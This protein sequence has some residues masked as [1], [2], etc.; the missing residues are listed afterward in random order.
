MCVYKL[1]YI[2]NYSECD[3]CFQKAIQLFA[4]TCTSERTTA[5]C[6]PRGFVTP[7]RPPLTLTP[8]LRPP[9]GLQHTTHNTQPH[10][11]HT[12]SLNCLQQ[13]FDNKPP[14][15]TMFAPPRRPRS[16]CGSRASAQRRGRS[17]SRTSRNGSTSD[18]SAAAKSVL[19]PLSANCNRRR[20]RRS[21]NKQL[22]HAST[23]T[24]YVCNPC[25]H[26]LS[27]HPYSNL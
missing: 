8:P 13:A 14:P 20:R 18:A 22:A 25:A 12:S 17:L 6:Q 23:S 3:R 5:F 2:Q 26:L 27:W 10:Y 19:R 15:K 9:L 7:H 24:K 16:Q 11:T 21:N 1:C 4:E